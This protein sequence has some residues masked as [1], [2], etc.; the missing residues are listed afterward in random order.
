MSWGLNVK[1]RTS[2]SAFTSSVKPL[3][4]IQVNKFFFPLNIS[5]GLR[6]I[7]LQANNIHCLI[8]RNIRIREHKLRFFHRQR[9]LVSP[10][11]LLTRRNYIFT[12][13]NAIFSWGGGGGEESRKLYFLQFC[14]I[15]RLR[16]K[17]ILSQITVLKP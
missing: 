12:R 8:T 14:R 7:I 15:K 17:W 10:S 2:R 5:S 9:W 13:S 11:E 4:I 3:L 6:S 16:F 1:Y